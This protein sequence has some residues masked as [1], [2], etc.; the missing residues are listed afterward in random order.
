MVL[1]GTCRENI[2]QRNFAE[3]RKRARETESARGENKKIREWV[4]A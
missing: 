1:Y 2:K 3:R 4:D